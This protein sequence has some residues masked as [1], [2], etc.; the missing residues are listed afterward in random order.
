LAQ[1]LQPSAGFDLRG[2]RRM[3]ASCP[4]ARSKPMSLRL[5]WVSVAAAAAAPVAP[6][7]TP[8]SEAEECTFFAGTT[9]EDSNPFEFFHVYGNGSRVQVPPQGGP[10]AC[11]FPGTTCD[12]HDCRCTASAWAA[13]L[14]SRASVLNQV[15]GGAV[16][17]VFIAAVR[18][19]RRRRRQPDAQ[20]A[21]KRGGGGR[22]ALLGQLCIYLGIGASVFCQ[23]YIAESTQLALSVTERNS[24]LAADAILTPIR[25]VFQFLEDSVSVKV[26]S[27]VGLALAGRG[28]TEAVSTVLSLGLAGG[29]VTGGCA[30]T[31][32]SLLTLWPAAISALL[33]PGARSHSAS[34]LGC[35]LLP[36]AGSIVE[37]ARGFWLLSVWTWP[38]VFMMLILTG[39]MLAVGEL[40]CFGLATTVM[41]AVYLLAWS[42]LS[43]P[44]L[45]TLGGAGMLANASGLVVYLAHLATSRRLRE[46]WGFRFRLS[47][48]ALLT[49]G[50]HD[51]ASS[52]KRVL[53]KEG[54]QCMLVDLCGQL[55]ITAGVYVAGFMGTAEMYQVSAMQAAMPGFATA[56]AT[57]VA[58]VLKLAGAMILGSG[59]VAA[60]RR[61]CG[62]AAAAA[63]A[64]VTLPILV[65]FMW[66][67]SYALAFHFG[68]QACV[69]A[70]ALE[71]SPI[72]EGMFGTRNLSGTLQRSFTAFAFA[73]SSKCLYMLA[74]AAL[75]SCLDFSFMAQASVVVL[76]VV[77]APAMCVARL[78]FDSVLAVYV[79]MYLPTLVMAVVFAA[80]LAVNT[81]RMADGKAG[82]WSGVAVAVVGGGCG[83]ARPPP[84]PPPPP[85]P[86]GLF[87][88]TR[89]GA[90][91]IDTSSPP[92]VGL[93]SPTRGGTDHIMRA[94]CDDC[95]AA[96]TGR[97]QECPCQ[98]A[99]ASFR[100]LGLPACVR[101]W[102]A[103][104]RGAGSERASELSEA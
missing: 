3:R 9:G 12:E 17:V 54:F 61:L 22:E 39:F 19:S 57:G 91:N 55:S 11:L 104:P 47:V 81:Q 97:N 85:P 8:T 98:P 59:D 63:L 14:Y 92:P 72:Y 46:K 10:G 74:K 103:A 86:A 52:S 67:D 24:M 82:P 41:A 64:L 18:R 70:T 58:Y 37:S 53:L 48:G 1:A 73:A 40:V 23:V 65:V 99:H 16:M 44:S 6:D 76:V 101:A 96:T 89:G 43:P 77:F 84:P 21:P 49:A 83:T 102:S 5:L 56:Y 2:A 87:S 20:E 50:K 26:G 25:E 95:S 35:S 80:R 38:C 100:M 93:F 79:A 68:E 15:C 94:D 29:L 90:D 13:G 51:D 27:L 62:Q 45:L 69:F 30:A 28:S 4:G 32:A 78:Y 42:L 71:C 75:Y 88:P 33:A 60:F 34:V 66:A 7:A 31:L 36:D